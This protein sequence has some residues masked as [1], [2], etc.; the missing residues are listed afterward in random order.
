MMTHVV[1]VIAE[2]GVDFVIEYNIGETTDMIKAMF[3]EVWGLIADGK[4]KLG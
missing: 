1:G 3:G 4:V 2:Q